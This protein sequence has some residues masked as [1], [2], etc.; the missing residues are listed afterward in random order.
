MKF[1]RSKVFKNV[2]F[3]KEKVHVRSWRCGI[4]GTDATPTFPLTV[5]IILDHPVYHL[6]DYRFYRDLPASSTM[7]VQITSPKE[8]TSYPC[9]PC[10]SLVQ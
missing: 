5:P 8:W 7:F 1:S 4:N 2:V 9:K 10:V 3:I 6:F